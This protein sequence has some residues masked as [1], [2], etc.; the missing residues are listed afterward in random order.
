MFEKGGYIVYGTTG[1]CQVE[2]ITALRMKG[3]AEDRLYY[4][5]SPCFRRGN[6]IFT[7][8]DNERTIM[9]SVM[10]REEAEALLDVIP[11]IE[12]L[13]ESGGKEREKQYKDAIRSCDPRQWVRIIKTSYLRGQ[14]RL[15]Q[16][17]PLTS[18]DERYQKAAEE[19]LY[20]ELAVA[21]GKKKE[22]IPAYIGQ[23]IG[24]QKGQAE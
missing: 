3:A 17:K 19:Q 11:Q 14:R 24:A 12:E 23:R 6:T 7:P 16:G 22:E 15:A 9:R 10:S 21:L 5:L 13:L 2:E 1:V 4:V 8:V 18:V 20:E